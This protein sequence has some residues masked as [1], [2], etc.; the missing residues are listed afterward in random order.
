MNLWRATNLDSVKR[1][2]SALRVELY[3]PDTLARLSRRFD[4]LDGGII[5]VD[6]ERLP[7]F[8]EGV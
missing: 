8:G 6:E 1:A 3:T 2:T 7:S 5:A 4:A